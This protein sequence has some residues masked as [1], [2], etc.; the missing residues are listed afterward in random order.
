M[1]N[2]INQSILN[3]SKFSFLLGLSTTFNYNILGNFFLFEICILFIFFLNFKLS[4]FN[5]I[6]KKILKLALYLAT[7]IFITDVYNNVNFNLILKSLANYLFLILVSLGIYSLY[8]DKNSKAVNYLF[9]GIILG[10]ITGRYFF[11]S[12]LYFELNNWKWGLGFLIISLFFIILDFKKKNFNIFLII[13]FNLIFLSISLLNNARWLSLVIIVANILYIIFNAKINFI[14]NSFTFIISIIFFFFILGEIPNYEITKKIFP[15]FYERNT[16]NNPYNKNQ[17][18]AS[19]YTIFIIKD[20]VKERPFVGHGSYSED[21][22]LYYNQLLRDYLYSNFYSDTELALPSKDYRLPT[23]SILLTSIAENGLLVVFFWIAY[24]SF[25][26]NLILSNESLKIN[27]LYIFFL[28]YFVN[29]LFFQPL[30]FSHRLELITIISFILIKS[31][32]KKE[33]EINN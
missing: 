27:Y 22:N 7:V 16:Q 5:K 4:R 20:I 14:K 26:I 12:Q 24:V 2:F 9:I 25:L 23:H 13:I 29:Y 15:D 6:E 10:Q 3:K 1:N 11:E 21:K 33:I 18:L 32:K 17:V 28:V 31:F 8:K 19:R 30:G